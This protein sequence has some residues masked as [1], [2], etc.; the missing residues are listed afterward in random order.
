MAES[1]ITRKGGGGGVDLNAT[2]QRD[3]AFSLFTLDEQLYT[4]VNTTAT[5]LTINNSFGAL[6]SDNNKLYGFTSTSTTF[7]KSQINKTNPVAYIVDTNNIRNPAAN[8]SG[9]IEARRVLYINNNNFYYD[10]TAASTITKFNENFGVVSTHSY[11]GFMVGVNIGFNPLFMHK[12]FIYYATG[13]SNIRQNGLITVINEQT[14]AVVSNNTTIPDR[15]TARFFASNNSVVWLTEYDN[16]NMVARRF[17]ANTGI[18]NTAQTATLV[19]GTIPI[20]GDRFSYIGVKDNFLYI[21]FNGMTRLNMDNFVQTN[22]GV[23]NRGKNWQGPSFIQG[24]NH[25]FSPQHVVYANNF[26]YMQGHFGP[27]SPSLDTNNRKLIQTI[28]AMPRSLTIGYDFNLS[29]VHFYRD[30]LTAWDGT[31]SG[32]G[33]TDIQFHNDH[34]YAVSHGQLSEGPSFRHFYIRKAALVDSYVTINNTDYYLVK[35]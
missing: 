18:L 10:I 35:K 27:V 9:S 8:I 4:T 30:A 14:M 20:S 7:N 23:I 3:T 6:I 21:P 32:V 19:A 17:Q 11:A 31:S 24:D 26:I 13:R 1:Y 16:G 29:N 34:L 2:N 25:G 22:T 33:V 15:G 5:H 28:T 12:G